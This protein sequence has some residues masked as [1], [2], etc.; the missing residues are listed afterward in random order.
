MPTKEEVQDASDA[1]AIGDEEQHL[2]PRF[3]QLAEQQQQMQEFLEYQAQQDLQRTADTELEKEISDFT[4]THKDVSPQDLQD[5]LARAAFIAQQNFAQGKEVIPS[6]DEVYTGWFTELRNRFL[7]AQRPGDLAPKLLPTNGG[8]PS[9]AQTG[10]KLGEL[11]N[12]QVQ[13]FIAA[14]IAAENSTGR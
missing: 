6:L 8:S 4:S 5:I 14:Q 2:D 13:D 11:S 10:V 3:D 12:Q 9:S 7:S 1:G